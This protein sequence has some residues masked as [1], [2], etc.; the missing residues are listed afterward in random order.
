METLGVQRAREFRELYERLVNDDVE[1]NEETAAAERVQ[2]LLQLKSVA[3]RHTC[4]ASSN[5]ESLIEQELFLLSTRVQPERLKHL[6]SRIRLCFLRL[7]RGALRHDLRIKVYYT[8][9][10]TH[11]RVL[12]LISKRECLL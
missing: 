6:R 12:P 10:H 8:H 2:L 9:T 11:I 4:A 3:T 7:A 5:L 1:A